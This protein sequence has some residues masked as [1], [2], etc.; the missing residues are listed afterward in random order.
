M[1]GDQRISQASELL[2]PAVQVLD[3]KMG[4]MEA[5]VG[6]AMQNMQAQTASAFQSVEQRILSHE[7]QFGQVL[8]AVRDATNQL[9]VSQT[10][11]A[12]ATNR[13]L[14]WETCG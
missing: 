13:K 1:A 10:Q 12:T 7:Q 2:T 6:Q 5:Q 3:T 14:C 4:V 11:V 9:H 8:Q